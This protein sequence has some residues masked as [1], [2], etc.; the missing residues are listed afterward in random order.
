MLCCGEPFRIGS[1]DGSAPLAV[2]PVWLAS[3]PYLPHPLRSARIPLWLICALRC[4]RARSGSAGGCS[5]L[6]LLRP[7]SIQLRE[8]GPIAQRP[9]PHARPLSDP[10]DGVGERRAELHQQD[11]FRPATNRALADRCATRS[12]LASSERGVLQRIAHLL[13]PVYL[14][15]KM[16]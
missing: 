1:Q 6:A 14:R 8:L 12:M 2:S 16:W 9:R 13:V 5:L 7:P 4:L 3:A 10:M 15:R 11:V